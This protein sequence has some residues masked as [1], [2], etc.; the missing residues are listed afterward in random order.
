MGK[1]ATFASDDPILKVI[2]AKK[3]NVPD[4]F[5]PSLTA[6][7]QRD[8]PLGYVDFE[9][10]REI[11]S[12]EYAVDFLLRIARVRET[13]LQ[14][15]APIHYCTDREHCSVCNVKVRSNHDFSAAIRKVFA[16][17]T[18]SEDTSPVTETSQT[19]STTPSPWVSQSSSPFRRRRGRY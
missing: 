3:Y 13:C 14:P 4:W 6:L 5:M 16:S 12:T 2:L 7:A 9:R 10:L 11:G 19:S 8:E 17:E 18:Q 1:L 15:A